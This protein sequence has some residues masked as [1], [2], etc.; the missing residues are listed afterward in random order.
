LENKYSDFHLMIRSLS[1]NLDLAT[2]LYKAAHQLLVA[3]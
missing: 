3:I 1:I 2:P